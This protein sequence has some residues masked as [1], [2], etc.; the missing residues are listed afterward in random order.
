MVFVLNHPNGLMDS[1]VLKAALKRPIAF[2]AK[3]TLF[4]N[5]LGKAV[6]E[7]FDSLPVYRRRD[8]GLPG[9]PKGDANERNEVTFA[10]C[11]A[12]LAQKGAIALF[13][14]LWRHVMDPRVARWSSDVPP[15]A[16]A[17]VSQ[18]VMSR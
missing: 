11:R 10:R 15:A 8:D 12:I 3:S 18:P 13:P 14:P 2:L 1:L 17:S 4:G 7:A 6:M 9:G 16:P 5:P